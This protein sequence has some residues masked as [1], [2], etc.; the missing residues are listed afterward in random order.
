MEQRGLLLFSI[1]YFS[2]CQVLI[3]WLRWI[4][5][6]VLLQRAYER[7]SVLRIYILY[8][9]GVMCARRATLEVS[10]TTLPNPAI[11]NFISA[12]SSSPLFPITPRTRPLASRS[13]SSAWNDLDPNSLFTAAG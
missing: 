2:T 1:L 7:V 12:M 3:D 6:A 5:T 11:S 13:L 8:E 10:E 9:W 4:R